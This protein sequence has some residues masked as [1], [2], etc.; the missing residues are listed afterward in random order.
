M[1]LK[2][3][4]FLVKSLYFGQRPENPGQRNTIFQEKYFIEVV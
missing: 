1:E 2:K 4:M 3:K